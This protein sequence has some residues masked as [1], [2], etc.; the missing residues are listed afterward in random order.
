[1]L[2][3]LET[4]KIIS[5][6]FL[7]VYM[8]ITL[9]GIEGFFGMNWLVCLIGATCLGVLGEILTSYAYLVRDREK[10]ILPFHF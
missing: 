3:L 8:A 5:P 2:V 9:M 6:W 1:M 4:L 7:W 10:P